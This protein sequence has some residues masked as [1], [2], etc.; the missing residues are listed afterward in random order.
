MRKLFIFTSIL[1]L[2]IISSCQQGPGEEVLGT[3]FKNNYIGEVVIDLIPLMPPEK[4]H[5]DS[6][7]R[8]GTYI[9]NQGGYKATNVELTLVGFDEDQFYDRIF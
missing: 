5:E 7:F 9:R 6:D 2:L 4:V 3:D 8:V 1:I